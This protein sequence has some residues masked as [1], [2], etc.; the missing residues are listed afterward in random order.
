MASL[1]SLFSLTLGFC[2]LLNSGPLRAA[3]KT[4]PVVF[5][6]TLQ[7]KETFERLVY[8]AQVSSRMNARFNAETDGMVT[9]IF[10][11]VGAKVQRGD[12][13]LVIQN[14]DPAYNF[15]PLRVKATVAGTLAALEVSEGTQVSKGQVLGTLLDPK[16][17]KILVEVPANDLGNIRVGQ[18]A[19]LRADSSI[20]ALELRVEN[21]APLV[22]PS[23]GTGR[24]ELR[25]TGAVTPKIMPGLL[26]RVD[27]QGDSRQAIL[28]PQDA[29]VYREGKKFLRKVVKQR[30][31][32]VAVSL[33][34]TFGEDVEVLSGVQSGDV[35]VMR[36]SAFVG[37]GQEVSI[38]EPESEKAPSSVQAR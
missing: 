37:D 5:V 36:A 12:T 9:Q 3:P 25:L 18:K 30:A 32:F 31:K 28:V 13:L 1:N 26:A 35:I 23:T 14:T 17:L 24:A 29:I 2:L 7:A 8:P 34:V 6:G 21:V 33:G 11:N 22:D 15:A 20:E 16:N 27:I 38:F 19:T 4:K 10:K